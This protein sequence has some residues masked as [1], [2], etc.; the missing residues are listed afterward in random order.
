MKFPNKE[1]RERYE[2]CEF[3][4]AYKSLTKG[5]KLEIVCKSEKPDFIVR[6]TVTGE[7]LGVE[8][9]S[10]YINDRSVP[11]VHMLKCEGLK[12]IPFD[13]DELER[14]TQRLISAIIDKVCKARS[15]Y[16]TD[17]PLILAIYVNEYIAIYLGKTDLEQLV[18]CHKGVF[19]S[20][21]P[22]SE[23][24]FFNLGNSA[25]FAVKLE[26]QHLTTDWVRS[27]C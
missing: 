7:K 27:L 13:K 14:Y 11:D 9:T 4:K 1:E 10:V 19:N 21:A 18:E 2:I 15:G 24:V 23:I 17:K 22:F 3:L 20:I 12:H 26:G 8:L 5:R 6:D 16:A 25:V